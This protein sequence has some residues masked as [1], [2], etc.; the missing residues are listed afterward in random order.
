MKKHRTINLH[1]VK[2]KERSDWV[3]IDASRPSCSQKKEERAPSDVVYTFTPR[4]RRAPGDPA[5]S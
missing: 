3:T 2:S 1:F 5:W 4:R